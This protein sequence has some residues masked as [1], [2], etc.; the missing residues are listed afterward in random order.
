[1]FLRACS[2]KPILC[3]ECVFSE[4]ILLKKAGFRALQNLLSSKAEKFSRLSRD[5]RFDFRK[6]LPFYQ[7]P[8]MLRRKFSDLAEFVFLENHGFCFW[9]LSVFKILLCIQTS[10]VWQTM[11]DRLDRA[12]WIR[13][14]LNLNN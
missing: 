8:G 5:S 1:M 2:S 9:K 14:D 3:L 12:L 10:N 11:F 4:A 6:R 13:N 7:L